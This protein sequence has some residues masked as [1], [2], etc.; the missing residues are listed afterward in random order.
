MNLEHCPLRALY[1]LAPLKGAESLQYGESPAG[2][3]R[4]QVR[5]P[6]PAE[7]LLVHPIGV[8][9]NWGF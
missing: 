6:V 7:V 2:G 4:V 1:P 5:K 3:G 9:L 8:V